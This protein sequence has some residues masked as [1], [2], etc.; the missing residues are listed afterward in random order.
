MRA[1]NNGSSEKDSKVRPASGV[2]TMHTVGPSSTCTFL[3]R[4]SAARTSPSWRTRSGFQVDPT[5][6]PEG[7]DRERRPIRLSPRTPDGPS[8]TLSAGMPR[9]STGGRYHMLAPAV[10]EVFSSRVIASTRRSISLSI[11]VWL[12]VSMSISMPKVIS[13]RVDEGS[14]TTGGPGRSRPGCRPGRV[15]GVHEAPPSQGRVDHVVD[16]EVLGHVDRLPV[17]VGA[18]NH[19]VEGRRPLPGVV[20]EV[21]LAP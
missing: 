20:Y 14:T 3:E 6:V 1:V 9:R 18:G 17:L 7:T 2:R 21:E 5:A 13:P 15:E 16:L 4:A 19:G 12:C 8:D 11:S 10:S